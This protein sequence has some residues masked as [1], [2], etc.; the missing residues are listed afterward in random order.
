MI[1]K[2]NYTKT[3]VSK[4]LTK[5]YNKAGDVVDA[6]YTKTEV[7][8]KR[9]V[10][11]GGMVLVKRLAIIDIENKIL[12][13]NLDVQLYNYLKLNQSK[14]GVVAYKGEPIGIK[15]IA[16]A[17]SISRRKVS[18]FISRCIEVDLVRKNKRALVL[19]PYLLLPYNNSKDINFLLQLDWKNNFKYSHEELLSIADSSKDEE[20]ISIVT[21]EKE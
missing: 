7:Y 19:N 5:H 21:Q 3:K 13:S 9:L 10:N 1:S 18:D 16:S 12:H 8:K 6:T 20:V 17:F 4:S 15:D 2:S 11:T 14:S